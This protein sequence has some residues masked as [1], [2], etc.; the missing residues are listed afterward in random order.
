MHMSKSVLKWMD[1]SRQTN[2]SAYIIA[3]IEGDFPKNAL[4]INGYSQANTSENEDFN[5]TFDA[6]NNGV[7]SIK[8]IKYQYG[9]EGKY[10]E[11]NIKFEEAITPNLALSF[12]LNLKFDGVSGLGK[13]P[14]Y[15]NITEV[16]GKPNGAKSSSLNFDLNVYPFVPTNRVLIEEYTGLWCGWCPRGYVAMEIIAKEYRDKAVPVCFH[17]GDEMTVTSIFPMD[18]SGYPKGT[19]NRIE[20]L[21]PYFGS[22]PEKD[23][24]ISYDVENLSSQLTKGDIEINAILDGTTVKAN[25]IV[26]FIDDYTD[27]D[28]E[29]GYIL[30]CN[31]LSDPTWIQINDYSGLQGYENSR[32]AEL[33]TWGSIVPGLVFNDVVVDVDGMFGIPG[34]IPSKIEMAKEYSHNYSFDISENE[35]VKNPSDLNVVAFIID[36]QTDKVVNSNIYRFSPLAGISSIEEVKSVSKTYYDF[37]GRIIDHP[38]KGTY[39]LREKMPNGQYKIS[40]ILIP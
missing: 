33:P 27:A 9:E 11:G 36:R 17:N 22:Y 26:K 2:G 29:I 21:D 40:K 23:F 35:L 1:Y 15:M 5:I 38:Q 32:L 4:T 37:S 19:I 14:F 10:K 8:S 18:V 12:P 39:I 13:H 30:T 28:Y 3:S 34:S 7:E 25:A 6:I 20:E 31:G 24:G 16:N